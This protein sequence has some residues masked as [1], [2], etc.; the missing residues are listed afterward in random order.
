MHI[1]VTL[2]ETG[3]TVQKN[4]NAAL[5]F[6]LF[7]GFLFFVLLSQGSKA[8]CGHRKAYFILFFSQMLCFNMLKSIL[9]DVS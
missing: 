9:L 7:F 1:C 5:F 2:K 4:V 3:G 6:T 8:L